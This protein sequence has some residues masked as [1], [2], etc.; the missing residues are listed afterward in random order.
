MVSNYNI[1]VYDG[2]E[3][4]GFIQ[5]FEVDTNL[6]NISI[7]RMAIYT[8]KYPKFNG[9]YLPLNIFKFIIDSKRPLKIIKE[10]NTGKLEIYS[11]CI[12]EIY[13]T[14]CATSTIAVAE[15]IILKYS[16]AKPND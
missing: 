3:R 2:I 6:K 5:D 11:D 16:V 9:N 1:T 8:G 4:I 7:T 13:G 14:S 10:Y 15:D 12:M